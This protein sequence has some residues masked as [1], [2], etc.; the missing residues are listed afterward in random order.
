M[1]RGCP[2]LESAT[3]VQQRRAQIDSGVCPGLASLDPSFAPLRTWPLRKWYYAQRRDGAAPLWYYHVPAREHRPSDDPRF[4]DLVDPPLRRLCRLIHA[5]GL[6]TTPSCAGHWYLRER[7]VRIWDE[8]QQNADVIRGVGLTVL[9]SETGQCGVF[10]EPAYRLPWRDFDE[11]FWRAAAL[12]RRGYI[13]IAIPP[14]WRSPAERANLVQRLQNKRIAMP[15]ATMRFDAELSRVLRQTLC[16]VF[17]TPA[18][19]DERG[20]AWSEVTD[21]FEAALAGFR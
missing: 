16:G 15:A 7:F 13:G 14:N 6:M 5:A 2:G 18:T 20:A 9:D 21:Y 8:L 4:Y 3:T 1:A 11:F 17:V 10:R 12:Q 19:L